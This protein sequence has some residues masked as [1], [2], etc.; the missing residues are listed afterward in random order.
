MHAML[1]PSKKKF[2]DNSKEYER[3]LQHNFVIRALE[4]EKYNQ[5]N[6]LLIQELLDQ[7]FPSCL[8]DDDDHAKS[9]ENSIKNYMKLRRV[10]KRFNTVLTFE[11]I[12]NFCHN[13][14]PQIK[15]QTFRK[16]IKPTYGPYD[17]IKHLP[18]LIVL[19][20][21]IDINPQTELNSLLLDAVRANDIHV[22][23][24]LFKHHANPNAQN[25]SCPVFFQA[26]TVEIAQIFICNKVDVHMISSWPMTNVLWEITKNE[27]PSELLELYLAHQVDAK[28][29]RPFDDACVLHAFADQILSKIIKNID[30]F[31]KKGQLLLDAIPDM[32][33]AL[34]KD[35]QTPLDIAQKSLYEAKKSKHGTPHAFEQLIIL[36]RKYGCLTAQE[37]EK[38]LYLSSH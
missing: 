14:T 32:V 3:Y 27:Y 19:C 29:L 38:S 6:P 17:T 15:S 4:A 28:K 36:F 21:G 9:L 12:G 7:I 1:N 31:L 13:Y 34:N 5:H 22:A 8:A 25:D 2:N 37:F 10:C 30:D 18:A 35:G 11:V 24:T 20:A 33:N 26:K 16:L 23:T